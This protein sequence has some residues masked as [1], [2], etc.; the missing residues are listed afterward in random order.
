MVFGTLAVVHIDVYAWLM[1]PYQLFAYYVYAR[2]LEP[3]QL[4]ACMCIC[5]ILGTLPVVPIYV[6]M[7]GFWNPINCFHIFIYAQFLEPYQLFAHMCICMIFG[8]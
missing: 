5:L 3:Y 7:H 2:F 4:F 6:H 1:E 8:T